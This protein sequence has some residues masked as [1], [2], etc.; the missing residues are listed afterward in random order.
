[1]TPHIL[2]PRH[3]EGQV[4]LE[5]TSVQVIMDG[6]VVLDLTWQSA[7]QLAKAMHTVAKKA[8]EL[9]NVEKVILDQAIL[10][11]AG[12]GIGLV[13]NPTMAKEAIKVAQFDKKLRRY[14]KQSKIERHGIVYGASVYHEKKK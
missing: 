14:I 8:E 2:V 6:N 1:M 7:L 4:R 12:T 11:R 3:K 9:E 5:G 13:T 10:M